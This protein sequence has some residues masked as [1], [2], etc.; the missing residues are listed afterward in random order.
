MTPRGAFPIEVWTD[1]RQ[2]LARLVMPMSS[3]VVI[4]DDLTSVM[5]REDHGQNP[6]DEAVFISANGFTIGATITKA[7]G[8]DR[9]GARRHSHSW[10]GKSRA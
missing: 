2:R 8:R 1:D 4:R 9:A 7:A 5:T 3:V 6:G 10:P